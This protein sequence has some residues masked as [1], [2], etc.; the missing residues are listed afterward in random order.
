LQD[1]IDFKKAEIEELKQST[2]LLLLRKAK[3]Q[4]EQTSLIA[5]LKSQLEA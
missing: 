1:L 2:I 4:D 5:S 3:E